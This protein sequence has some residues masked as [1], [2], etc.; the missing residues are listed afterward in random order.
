M[1]KSNNL[2]ALVLFVAL[3]ALQV[4]IATEI[5]TYG[6]SMP[7]SKTGGEKKIRNETI[8]VMLN[9]TFFDDLQENVIVPA[10]FNLE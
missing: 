10:I 1:K 2:M 9:Q 6:L 3:G 4:S 7:Y 8:R 5:N